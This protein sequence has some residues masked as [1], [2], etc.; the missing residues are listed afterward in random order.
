MKRFKQIIF[1][2]V[3]GSVIALFVGCASS[4]SGMG[5][6]GNNERMDDTLPVVDEVRVLADVTSVAL[7][8]NPIQNPDDL[9][10]FALYQLGSNGVAKKIAVIKNP[11]ATH[12]VV[13]SLIPET[14]YA[15]EIVTLGKDNAISAKSQTIN[16]KTSFIDPVEEVFASDN[17][18]KMIKLIWSPHPNPSIAQYIIQR[19]QRKGGDERFLNLATIKDRLMVEFFDKDL[20]D[21]K[22]YTYR[23][24]A[25]DFNGAKSRLSKIVTGKTRKKPK[26]I[27]NLAASVDLA[28]RII[29]RWDKISGIEKYE[30]YASNTKNGR[31]SLIATTT[32]NSY[33]DRI[34]RDDITR[35]YKVSAVD[36]GRVIGEPSNQAQGRTLPALPIPRIT[37][38]TMR[39]NQAVIQWEV[40][41]N[42]R[43]KAYAVYRA[44]K[45][46]RA[47]RFADTTQNSFI[48]KEMQ[49]GVKYTYW[50][51]A[52][53]DD[54]NESEPS[55]KIELLA[56]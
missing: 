30:I 36:S 17:Q 45:R 27:Q 7:E 54:H 12:Y 24:I 44:E 29:L 22:E 51:V 11:Y 9:K 42:T 52:V 31:F 38:E 48:D 6:L 15:F 25:Q 26:T 10:G 53:D 47:L 8:W 43:V 5:F 49:K 55:Q 1:Y 50:V 34:Q 32:N 19:K 3:L 40:I 41:N 39:D 21:G 46:G 33:I 14:R 18:P 16:V 56:P 13:N 2:S 35:F 28:K 4:H 20:L 23:I 37:N